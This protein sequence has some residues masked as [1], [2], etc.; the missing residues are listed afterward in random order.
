MNGNIFQL[1]YAQLTFYT[2]LCHCKGNL[3]DGSA[4]CWQDE[5]CGDVCLQSE[6]EISTKD[7]KIYCKNIIIFRINQMD[8][9]RDSWTIE[10]KKQNCF[11]NL[12]LRRG[13]GG[14]NILNFENENVIVPP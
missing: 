7:L 10:L 1:V 13:S 4:A 8:L 3:A 6:E 9:S 12:E 14:S 2:S 5:L 11:L